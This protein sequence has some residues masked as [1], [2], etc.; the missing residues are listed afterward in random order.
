MAVEP[1]N[2]A[3]PRRHYDLSGARRL[4]KRTPKK[5]GLWL[6]GATPRPRE[7]YPSGFANWLARFN[8]RRP[9]GYPNAWRMEPGTLRLDSPS[10]VVVVFHVYFVD[11]ID[12][13]IEQLKDI[14]VE[15]DL[16]VTNSSSTPL[17]AERFAGA[18]AQSVR[19][20]PTP[21]QGRDIYPLV[22][23]INSGLLDGAD[24]VLK[25]HTKKS[26]WRN[27]R[28][29]FAGTGTDWRTGFLSQ[30]LGGRENI[31]TILSSFADD[32]SLGVVTSDG[33][34]LGPE[35]WGGDEAIARG[36]LQ[37]LELELDATALRFPAGSMYWVRSFVLQG[38]RSFSFSIDDFEPEAGQ[39]D[40]TVAHAIERLVGIVTEEAGL[41]I[42][43]RHE[44]PDTVAS[45]AWKR[46]STEHEP[47]VRS[48]VIP[49]YLPQF[50]AFDENDRWWGPGFTEWT[51][52]AAARPVFDGH[53]QPL[54][55]S[56]LGFYDLS[57]DDVRERQLA[58]AAQHGVAG[59]MYYYY[60]FAG[61]RLMS[62]PIE[63]LLASD[64]DQ[65]FCVMWANENWTRR[66]DGQQN[67]VLIGQHYD[68][69]PA[70]DF[71]DDILD[72][73]AD[74]RYLRV[75]NRPVLAV[76]RFTSLPDYVKTVTHWRARAREAGVGELHILSVDFVSDGENL[77]TD[78][79]HIDGRL[80]F[81]PH[82]HLWSW[83]PH[84]ELRPNPQFEGSIL[85]YVDMARDSESRLASGETPDDYYPGVMVNFDNT[86][87][88]QWKPDIW[89]GSNPYTFRRWL[90]A[91]VEALQ[92]RPADE[93][94]VFVNAWN[95]WAEGAVLEPTTRFGR[96]YLHAV[97]SAALD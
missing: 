68:E 39:V 2:E 69:V 91:A 14:P 85:N 73:L 96:A 35:Y 13:I 5:I 36:L 1:D 93:R 16:L 80:G 97:R 83:M 71:I 57:H 70:E 65:P 20:L 66:W 26:E 95:E 4:I 10:K 40:G 74:P 59:L 60:W 32:L 22:S 44:L 46:F 47:S 88:R 38:M 64:L 43:E 90:S 8:P 25:V 58:L 77:D 21:N 89:V 12:E 67:D 55:P 9:H 92:H 15:F 29:D 94:I 76:Y 34:V 11:M 51:N 49:F 7:P 27:D 41:T 53:R 63:S 24:L 17:D 3:V 54:I 23:V 48:R 19:V 72:F 86:A 82:N 61:K 78:N 87:R 62:K 84:K 31:E 37:R 18:G 28:A 79:E 45:D 75:N 42:A 52:V 56:E 50:H 33:N 81:P 6:A 30:L